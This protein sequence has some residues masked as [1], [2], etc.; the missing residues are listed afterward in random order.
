MRMN[1]SGNTFIGFAAILTGLAI[2]TASAQAPAF[3][4]GPYT[5][6]VS[7]K[8]GYVA[9]VLW[10]NANDSAN[11]LARP[12]KREVIALNQSSCNWGISPVQAPR[13]ARVSVIGK[14]RGFIYSGVPRVIVLYGTVFN[15]NWKVQQ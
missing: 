1:R 5:Q 13:H 10:F 12:H 15:A 4:P 11:D 14:K 2:G 3:N 7:N 6:C 8:G 9:E